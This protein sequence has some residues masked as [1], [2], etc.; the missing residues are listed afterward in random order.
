MRREKA[1]ADKKG[2][3]DA[4]AKTKAAPG[5]KR[6]LSH[7]DD[8][9]VKPPKMFKTKVCDFWLKWKCTRGSSCTFI[10]AALCSSLR[11]SPFCPMCKT[12]YA[13]PGPMPS[14]SMIW[15]RTDNDCEGCVL[16]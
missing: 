11:A 14:G 6:K 15:T 3:A 4:T 10:Q 13:V 16:A 1:K 12:K 5:G 7:T 2:K 9:D 8:A